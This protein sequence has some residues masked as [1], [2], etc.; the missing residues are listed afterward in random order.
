[1]VLPAG[2]VEELPAPSSVAAMEIEPGGLGLLNKAGER[3]TVLWSRLALLSAAGFKEVTAKRV[4]VSEG[5][6]MAQKAASLGLLM[7]GIPLRLGPKK[8]ETE[9][10]VET[11][12]LVFYLDL[13]ERKPVRRFRVDAQ[14]FNYSCLGE[15]MKYAATDN[16]R[17]LVEMIAS[18][19]GPVAL[20]AAACS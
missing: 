19:A 2:L 10:V 11:S 9:K 12:E 5:P 13:F 4:K 15:S 7:T 14:D 8:T 20:A 17:S 6:S 1:M 16:F 3:V 18:R